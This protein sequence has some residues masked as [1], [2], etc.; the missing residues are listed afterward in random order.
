MA[1]ADTRELIEG[2]VTRFLDD[3]PSL[4]TLKLVIRL[5]LRA[6]GDVPVWRVEVPGPTVKRDPAGDARLDIA[7]P[8]TFFNELAR[9]GRLE[10][11][12]EA[13]QHGYVKVTGDAAVMKLLANVIQRQRVRTGA[14]G[15]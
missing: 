1:T 13:Y 6:R 7:S 11:W 4:K 15:P 8:R 5:E 3:V 12:V 2:A 10:D 9:D 14:A